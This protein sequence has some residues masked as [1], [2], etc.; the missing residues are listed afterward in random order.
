[1]HN[2]ETLALSMTDRY[3]L[4]CETRVPANTDV[5][6]TCNKCEP[7]NPNTIC[8][9]ICILVFF[10]PWTSLESNSA[11]AKTTYQELGFTLD[12]ADNAADEL[13]AL[14]KTFEDAV[15]RAACAVL[16]RSE[17]CDKDNTNMYL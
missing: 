17:H 7:M 1:M 13:A 2:L 3:P 4:P 8:M 16:L 10:P 5:I 14:P 15:S 12:A 9:C 6:N 11:P